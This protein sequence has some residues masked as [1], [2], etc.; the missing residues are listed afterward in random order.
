MNNVTRSPCSSDGRYERHHRDNPRE[1]L[2]RLGDLK[3]SMIGKRDDHRVRAKAAECWSLC[4]FLIDLLRKYAAHLGDKGRYLL[5][6]GSCLRDLVRELVSAPT[7]LPPA[8]L[9]VRARNR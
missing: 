3:E 4:L 2:T 8:V 6:A 9:Q 5:E 7:N 1:T